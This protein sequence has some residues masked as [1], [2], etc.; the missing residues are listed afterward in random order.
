MFLGRIFLF[1]QRVEFRE[2]IFSLGERVYGSLFFT[3]TGFHG[4]HVFLGLFLLLVG[5][6]RLFLKHFTCLNHASLEMSF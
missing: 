5:G 4:F 6:L 2:A 3:L 1:N